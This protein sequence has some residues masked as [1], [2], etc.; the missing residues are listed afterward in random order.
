MFDNKFGKYV[1]RVHWGTV[2]RV[3]VQWLWLCWWWVL[4]F[5]HFGENSIDKKQSIW[6][7]GS[8]WPNNTRGTSHLGADKLVNGLGLRPLLRLWVARVIGSAIDFKWAAKSHKIGSLY[9]RIRVSNKSSTPDGTMHGLWL[10]KHHFIP[11]YV[12]SWILPAML[13]GTFD[14]SFTRFLQGTLPPLYHGLEW[15]SHKNVLFFL[16][17][18]YRGRWEFSKQVQGG[19]L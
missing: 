3:R 1:I 12:W 9:K 13:E 16:L 14:V 19:S 8:S 7:E 5:R 18:Y 4:W 11:Q 2:H 15:L 10:I 17:P 6:I